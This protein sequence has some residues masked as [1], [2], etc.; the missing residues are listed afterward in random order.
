MGEKITVYII[1]GT[2]Y[3]PRFSD[4]GNWVGKAIYG[5]R[6]RS[7]LREMCNL[8]AFPKDALDKKK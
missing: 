6:V 8:I 1:D 4:I 7:R 5:S 2:A 3:V